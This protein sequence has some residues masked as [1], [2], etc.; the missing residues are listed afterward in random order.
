M[1]QDMVGHISLALLREFEEL[2]VLKLE[3][4]LDSGQTSRVKGW[5]KAIVDRDQGIPASLEAEFE[6]EGNAIRKLRRLYWN[7]ESFWNGIFNESRLPYLAKSLVGAP[8]A[9]TFH[10]A[11]L[12]SARIGTPVALHQDQALWRFDYPNAVSI[13]LSLTSSTRHNGCLVGCPRSHKRGAIE[14]RDI[15]GHPWHQGVD[16]NIN[17]LGEP[18]PYELEPGDALVWN[19]YFVHGSGAN[20]SPNARWGIVMVFTD[21][22]QPNLQ[23][24]DRSDL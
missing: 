20:S 21:R 6:P 15:Q 5:L 17:R 1:S 3:R 4:L 24:T 16:W 12:K 2:G 19:R 11:F 22:T 10:A 23:T 8:V 14:H 13:W 7:D 9:L 18:I